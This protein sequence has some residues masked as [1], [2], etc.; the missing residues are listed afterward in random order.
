MNKKKLR[1]EMVL[2]GDTYET[3]SKVL[4]IATQTLGNKINGYNGSQFTQHEI[5]LIRDR[6]NLTDNEV[7]GIFFDTDVSKND[8]IEG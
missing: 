7:V 6:Y 3:L 5:V 8:T 4:G 1:S 2:Y